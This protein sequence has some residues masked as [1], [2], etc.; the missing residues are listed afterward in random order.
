MSTEYEDRLVGLEI[1]IERLTHTVE[2]LVNEALPKMA[3]RMA[4]LRT[5]LRDMA[6]PP[7]P[8]PK[9]RQAFRR[10]YPTSYEMWKSVMD[11]VHSGESIRK[12]SF[13]LGLPYS[14]AYGYA[15]MTTSEVMDLR[16]RSEAVNELPA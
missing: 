16:R 9:P 15:K 4:E 7:K 5:T 8:E 12:I 13:Q 10:R 11:L 2:R 14:T 3:A 1:S 6:P